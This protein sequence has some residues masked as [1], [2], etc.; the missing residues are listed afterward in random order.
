MIKYKGYKVLP[1]EVEDH[2]YEHPGVLECAVIGVPDPEIGETIK[3][4]V[5]IKEEYKDKIT[6]TELKDWAK[7]EMAGYKWPRIIEFIDQIPRTAIGKVSRKELRERE[8]E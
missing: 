7:N 2:M 3:A 5:V 6:E 8:K 1:D 4:F